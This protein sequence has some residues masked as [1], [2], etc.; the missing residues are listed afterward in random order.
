MYRTFNMGVGMVI[1]TAPENVAAITNHLER[2]YE[3][4]EVGELG[5]GNQTVSIE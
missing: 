2:C 4:G 5:E 3:I 1:V